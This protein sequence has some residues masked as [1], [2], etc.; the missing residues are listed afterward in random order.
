M[1]RA[2]IAKQRVG[3]KKCFCQSIKV[4]NDVLQGVQREDTKGDKLCVPTV[5][6]YNST[7]S[8]LPLHPLSTLRTIDFCSS[9][10]SRCPQT[11]LQ[12][13][14]C[15]VS[16][17]TLCIIVC[18]IPC[19]ILLAVPTILPRKTLS[20]AEPDQTSKHRFLDAHSPLPDTH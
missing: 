14:F 1:E 10:S 11:K 8:E 7:L 16:N 3:K 5:V 9:K 4:A 19:C 2:L 18:C 20:H 15:D 13:N 6:T 17:I 12:T